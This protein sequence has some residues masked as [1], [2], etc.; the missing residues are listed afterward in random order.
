MSDTESDTE[1][2]VRHQS[3][4]LVKSRTR[5]EEGG[6][7]KGGGGKGNRTER[8]RVRG[9][10]AASSAWSPPLQR[11]SEAAEDC[12]TGMSQA[13]KAHGEGAHGEQ[14]HAGAA[15]AEEGMQAP[16]CGADLCRLRR[17][18]QAS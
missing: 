5:K 15:H 1:V 10:R 14:P 3:C 9:A 8:K 4:K 13:E 2:Q 17:K 16:T 11:S 18:T 7:G 12:G 6:R